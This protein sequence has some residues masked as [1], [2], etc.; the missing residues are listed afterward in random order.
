MISI[1]PLAQWLSEI[2]VGHSVLCFIDSSTDTN[3][4]E[5]FTFQSRGQEGLR[6]NS[7]KLAPISHIRSAALECNL[8][9]SLC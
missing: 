3:S 1:F 4:T 8:C 7:K 6:N 5:F 2:S 9:E